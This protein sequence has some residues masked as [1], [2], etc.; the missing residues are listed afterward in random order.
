MDRIRSKESRRED[1]YVLWNLHNA[2]R[3]GIDLLFLGYRVSTAFYAF[4]TSNLRPSASR[5]YSNIYLKA[6]HLL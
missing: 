2:G 5:D 6:T 3:I 1:W 4:N